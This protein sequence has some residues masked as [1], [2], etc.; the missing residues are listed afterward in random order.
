MVYVEAFRHSTIVVRVELWV[1]QAALSPDAAALEDPETTT[2]TF[3]GLYVPPAPSPPPRSW[4]IACLFLYFCASIVQHD[5][6]TEVGHIHPC[7]YSSLA[8]PPRLLWVAQPPIIL[9]PRRISGLVASPVL[10]LVGSVSRTNFAGG[11]TV[12]GGGFL[13]VLSVLGSR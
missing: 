3:S 12:L 9:T 1:G 2:G 13:T 4:R 8:R 5:R 11:L 10:C 6:S 7:S